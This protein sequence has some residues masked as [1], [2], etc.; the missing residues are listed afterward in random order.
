MFSYLLSLA[1]LATAVY[2]QGE[3]NG[4]LFS[5]DNKK[6]VALL[7]LSLCMLAVDWTVKQ[8]YWATKANYHLLLFP[9]FVLAL[10]VEL[11]NNWILFFFFFLWIAM[12]YLV[13]I[14]Q[15]GRN[16][17]KVF[18]AF[19]FFFLGVLFF[20][21]GSVVLPLLWLVMLLKGALNFPYF[22][23]SLL[24]VLALFLLEV[25][26]VYFFPQSTLLSSFDF[27]SLTFRLPLAAVFRQNLWWG[28]MLLL[29]LMAI[30]KH[31]IDM[32]S[33]S[34]SYGAGMFALFSLAGTSLLFGLFFQNQSE[35]AWVLFL[36]ALTALS[37]RLFEDIKKAWLREFF[38][39]VIFLLLLLGK[40]GLPF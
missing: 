13:A 35:L 25:V 2:F 33:K 38:F 34:A 26:F 11:W 40:Y 22:L 8:H 10:P 30:L 18:N 20:P 39:T 17:A 23:I 36:M 12:N 1:L 6:N 16:I 5:L 14:D 28:I 7:L 27:S 15:S 37:T 29:L 24:P 31:Y 32:G 9:F 4:T 21:Q 3:I 19:F